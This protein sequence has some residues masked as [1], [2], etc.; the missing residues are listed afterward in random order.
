ML[1]ACPTSLYFSHSVSH[2][3]PSVT[4]ILSWQFIHFAS[5]ICNLSEL[6]ALEAHAELIGVERR[7]L[8]WPARAEGGTYSSRVRLRQALQG[9][10]FLRPTAR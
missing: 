7:A 8:R 5:A 4:C 9:R 10:S 6:E 3:S 2:C 1:M